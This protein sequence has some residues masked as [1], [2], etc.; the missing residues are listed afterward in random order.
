M[1]RCH[2][3][4][5]DGYKAATI[6]VN[7]D[8]DLSGTAQGI[9]ANIG[10]AV[11][12]VNG[13]G[14]ILV[15]E[16]AAKSNGYAAIRAEDSLVN[17][18]VKL[19]ETGKKATAG[20][21]NDVVIK[22]N[23]TASVGAVN[24]ID[25]NGTMTRINLALDTAKSSLDGALVNGF[26]R[27]DGTTGIDTEADEGGTVSKH[28]DGELNLWLQN[29]AQWNN[30]LY[31]SLKFF[32][33]DKYKTKFQGSHV[34][35]FVG[36]NDAAHTGYIAQNTS[37]KLTIDNYSGYATLFY[38]HTANTDLEDLDEDDEQYTE[39][40]ST[41]DGSQTWHYL[42][43]T[44][45]KKA[46]ADSHIA[47]ITDNANIN[48]ADSEQVNKVLNALAGKLYYN[49][50]VNNERNLAGTVSIADGLTAS[51][52]SKT[53]QSGDITFSETGQGSYSVEKPVK[54][55]FTT[56]I[57]GSASSDTEYVETVSA[58]MMAATYLLRIPL[59]P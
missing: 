16:K 38:S 26:D 41:L 47:L 19:D 54:T 48:T 25:T 23:V 51:S 44:I 50:Y 33:D 2:G 45:I 59:L 27:T 53:Y 24:S 28:F 56:P 20:L 46:A 14:K 3:S 4:R 52:F 30:K 42:G 6:T 32:S 55:E 40:A 49:A 58:R 31:G 17:M 43:D 13:G 8:V 18:N 9:F 34:T 11:V 29:G 10:G 7:G 21:G 37:E 12:T 22:G 1:L 57:T 36:G 15:D 35:D 5:T 39:D